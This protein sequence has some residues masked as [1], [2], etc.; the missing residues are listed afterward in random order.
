MQIQSN[1]WDES[2]IES[3]ASERLSH[4]SLPKIFLRQGVTELGLLMKKVN[5]RRNEN[6]KAAQAYRAMSIEEFEGINV[7]QVWCNWRTVPKN[8]N[9]LL[10]FD[11]PLRALDLCCGIGQSCEILACYLPPGST[12]LGIEQNPEFVAAARERVILDGK[13]QEA[14]VTFR[15]QSALETFHDENGDVIADESIDLVNSSGAIGHHFKAGMTLLCLQEVARVLKPEGIALIDSGVMGT[16][17][18]QVREIAAALG[19]TELRSNRSRWV[20]P[21]LQIA[22]RKSRH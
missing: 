14:K 2:I 10:P 18:H 15:A 8:L 9:G 1:H 20:D 4:E 6:E 12:I 5:F 21:L 16:K 22:F 11:R 13:G 17:P 3:V 19:W 7:R